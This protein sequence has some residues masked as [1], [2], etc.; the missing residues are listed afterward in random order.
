[1]NASRTATPQ[2]RTPSTQP[3]APRPSR[4][5]PTGGE[6]HTNKAADWEPE[7]WTASATAGRRLPSRDRLAGCA[8][9]AGH[10]PR[11]ALGSDYGLATGAPAVCQR[12]ERYAGT[13]AIVLTILVV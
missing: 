12:S 8:V 6:R 5:D 9:A 7:A 11:F 4:G 13:V 10:Q 2:R 1:M 3:D